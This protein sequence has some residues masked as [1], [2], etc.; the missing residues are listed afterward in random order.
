MGPCARAR[1]VRHPDAAQDPTMDYPLLKI[2]HIT[3]VAVTF[4]LFFGRGVLMLVDSPLLKARFLRIAPHVNDTLL[5]GSAL[6]MAVISRQYPFA[7]S[8]LTAKLVALIVYICAGMI[9]LSHGRTKH[10]RVTAWVFAL[11]VFAYIVSVAL[12]RSPVPFVSR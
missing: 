5:L 9:A 7:E 1:R 4:V 10:S 8:W 11:L 12:T 3:C 2:I 6:W